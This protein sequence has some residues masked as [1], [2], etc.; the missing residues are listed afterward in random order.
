M[1]N[2]LQ[3]AYF[4]FAEAASQFWY[5]ACG[6]LIEPGAI[7]KV[8]DQDPALRGMLI[9][10]EAST[11]PACFGA[12]LHSSLQEDVE[13]IFKSMERSISRLDASDEDVFKITVADAKQLWPVWKSSGLLQR[14]ESI[15][16]RFS[17]DVLNPKIAFDRHGLYVF[18]S[19]KVSCEAKTQRA[20][21]GGRIEGGT[22]AVK[23]VLVLSQ[24]F[25]VYSGLVWMNLM[26]SKMRALRNSGQ[27]QAGFLRN[28]EILC[29]MVDRLKWVNGA[30]GP[31]RRCRRVGLLDGKLE[32]TKDPQHCFVQ[33]AAYGTVH[34]FAENFRTRRISFEGTPDPKGLLCAC[35]LELVQS[36]ERVVEEFHSLIGP[37]RDIKPSQ[38]L[39]GPY[40]M[41]LCDVGEAGDWQ[42]PLLNI[43]TW[44]FSHPYE[45]A[46]TT[47][48]CYK[49]GHIFSCDDL[50]HK[51]CT[52][53][54]SKMTAAVESIQPEACVMNRHQEMFGVGVS[55]LSILLQM[56]D[57]GFE[58]LYDGFEGVF[59]ESGDFNLH[60][61]EHWHKLAH[62]LIRNMRFILYG[63][64]WQSLL[65][66]IERKIRIDPEFL[67]EDLSES[68]RA[69][70]MC[71]D[72]DPQQ[73][74]QAT[75]VGA[76]LS[77]EDVEMRRLPSE[78][79]YVD[80][81]P[82]PTSSWFPAEEES[83]AMRESVFDRPDSDTNMLQDFLAE[84]SFE[85]TCDEETF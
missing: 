29:K 61:Y 9:P 85:E 26:R 12:K 53:Y 35:G 78:S 43:R 66:R 6:E 40:G 77:G 37:H 48:L 4:S 74:V 83:E 10:S 16:K 64:E 17:V 7:V 67:Q 49:G 27:W 71:S 30:V 2:P 80:A 19:G 20:V 32:E 36:L 76:A 51:F 46:Q 54:I 24:S 57:G 62:A 25:H 39:L 5:L 65:D 72:R 44:M 13:S 23:L 22:K 3:S 50:R 55:S 18:L 41:S 42:K 28:H 59:S 56:V 15:L 68:S 14:I 34:Q 21:M 69:F 73:Q 45:L 33:Q 47:A 84:A 81:L 60:A 31:L 11:M 82:Q 1:T 58:R 75:E 8:S 70:P 79:S 63:E 52:E 38:F